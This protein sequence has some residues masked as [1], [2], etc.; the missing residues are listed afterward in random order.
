MA[1]PT[2]QGA[3]KD[4]SG[5]AV[6]ECDMPEPSKCP[7]LDSCQKRFVVG[8]QGSWCCSAPG[9]WTC[10]PSKGGRGV[11]SCQALGSDVVRGVGHDLPLFCADFHSI[12]RCSV[13]ESVGEV[14]KFTT[15]AAR[16]ISVAFHQ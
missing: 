15:D 14:L 2:L 11:S 8:P 7:S 9:R 10:A 4:G 16:K 6:V 13:Y 3:L 12:L 5:E 1:L